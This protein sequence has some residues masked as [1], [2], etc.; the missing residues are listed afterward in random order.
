M[1]VSSVTFS[2]DSRYVFSGSWDGT[3]RAWNVR[4]G[5][6]H[7]APLEADDTVIAVVTNR[8]GSQ[9]V[10]VT[11]AGTTQMWPTPSGAAG[12][13]AKLTANMSRKQWSEWV[14]ADIPYMEV[15]PG[16]PRPARLEN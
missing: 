10:S 4:Y 12:L 5:Q 9:V 13:R 2:A 14:S 11:D 15:C 6:P 16:A 1:R 8:D 3:V 7:G